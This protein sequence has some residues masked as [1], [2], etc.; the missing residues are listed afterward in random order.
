[1]NVYP[2]EEASLEEWLEYISSTHTQ[3]IEMGLSR[4]R[5]IFERLALAPTC[6]S[7]I[8]GGTNGKGST[9]AMLS[10]I[11]TSAG[12]NVGTYT[13]PHIWSFNE[14]ICIN[15]QPVTDASI[16]SAFRAIACA[17]G[18]IALT[19]FEWATLAA[20]WIFKYDHSAKKPDIWILEVGMGGRL[21][22]TNLIDATISV[23]TS[24]D[25]DHQHFLGNT[26][27]AIGLEKLGIA[28]PQRTLC[29]GDAS[30]PPEF[31]EAAK[32]QNIHLECLGQDFGYIAD[33]GQQWQYWYRSKQTDTALKQRF[34]LPW[35]ALRGSHQLSNASVV[36]T[37]LEHLK[38]THPV[39]MQ[40]V[41][42]GL[43]HV[44]WAGR[45]QVL[46][47]QPS[48]V[49]D[50]AHNPHAMQALARNLDNMGFFPI[51]WCIWGMLSDKDAQSC[52]KIL[53]PHVQQWVVCSLSGERA[54]SS[55]E[56]AQLL[57][58]MNVA[59]NTIHC[60]DSVETAYTWTRTHALPADRI[61]V[62]GSFSTLA[63]INKR[64]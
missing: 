44:T 57:K 12:Y 47:G 10:T 36:F 48:T 27:T 3:T 5:I 58:S 46:P 63:A 25:L 24:I 8:V 39:S 50:V 9:C 42:E 7:V 18:D 11:L 29:L 2:A 31:L 17:R 53:L 38:N 35:P 52:A 32:K 15:N 54:R 51:T 34:G 62:T 41:R 21:D 13:S 14:R 59:P 33:N 23:I 64:N 28:R 4:S 56:L 1:M 55:H 37:L 20:F 30:P 45:F 16:I 49:L 43:L 26:R 6:P 61:V 40:S 19:Y 22:T 60:F